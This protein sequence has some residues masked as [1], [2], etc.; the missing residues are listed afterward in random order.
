M[1]FLKSG[2]QRNNIINEK[3]I[4]IFNNNVLFKLKNKINNH[5]ILLSNNINPIINYENKKKKKKKNLF[6]HNNKA[7]EINLINNHYNLITTKNTNNF[8]NSPK[9]YS[10]KLFLKD[11]KEKK[12]K[13]FDDNYINSKPELV[14]EYNSEILINL[15]IE[16]FIINKNENT[17]VIFNIPSINP[18]IRSCLI[19]SL[20]GLQDTFKFHDKTF[21]ITVQLFDNFISSNLSS[22]SPVVKINEN[23]LDIIFA[24]CFLIASKYEETFI[25]HLKIWNIIL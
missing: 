9:E 12:I 25:Y 10:I 6:I 8:A 1:K 3:N 18:N 20:I 22:T 24:A 4:R 7:N 13:K 15:L 23:N 2:N 19:D 17:S 5:N 21:F 14:K 11:K 16:E